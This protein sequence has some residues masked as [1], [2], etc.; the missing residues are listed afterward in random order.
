VFV[1]KEINAI[2]TKQPRLTTKKGE[3]VR[4]TKKKSLVG[5]TPGFPKRHSR[6][7]CGPPKWSTRSSKMFNMIN[8]IKN[9]ALYQTLS[10]N[11]ALGHWCCGPARPLSLR[12]LTRLEN[13][14]WFC[15]FQFKLS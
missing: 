12:P 13:R 11:M 15:G 3:N 1:T 6:A 2:T 4:F 14:I 10:K 9:V 8:H 5:L 7:A